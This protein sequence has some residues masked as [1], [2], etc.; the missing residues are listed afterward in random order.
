MYFWL[1]LASLMGIIMFGNYREKAKDADDYIVPVYEALAQNMLIQHN[2]VVSNI[3]ARIAAD[4]QVPGNTG[5]EAFGA[6]GLTNQI[7]GDASGNMVDASNG[8]VNYLP[9]GFK[10]QPG[11]TTSYFCVNK[12]NQKQFIACSNTNA[13][14]YV[15]TYG[16]VPVKYAGWAAMSIPKAIAAGTRNS[17][18]VGL[19]AQAP[20]PLA[21][22]Y[23]QPL[24]AGY[25]ILSAGYS[26]ASSTYIPDAFF[27]AWGQSDPRNYMVA[28][29]MIKGLNSGENMPSAG[30]PCS[31]PP[32]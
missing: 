21:A 24:G 31:W 28:L 23:G 25:Y 13:V 29:T 26:P 11:V 27:C 10:Y 15:I 16:S 17:R 5:Y 30:S 2:A 8:A 14:M 19:I 20:A 18:F 12:A 22:G 9:Y 6:S 1:M 7:S 32:S 3:Q 4:S